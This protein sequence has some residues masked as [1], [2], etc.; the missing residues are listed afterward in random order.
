MLVGSDWLTV[1]F[2]PDPAVIVTAF[3]LLAA[4]GVVFGY[5]L[6]RR[7]ARLTLNPIEALRHK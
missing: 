1:P 3:G 5:F 7:A 4:V 2:R 6:A